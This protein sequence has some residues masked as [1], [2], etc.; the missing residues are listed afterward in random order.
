MA[1]GWPYKYFA[2]EGIITSVLKK[3]IAIAHSPVS[4]TMEEHEIKERLF[5]DDIIDLALREHPGNFE[6]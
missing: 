6:V 2:W 3:R 1:A 4:S 5:I